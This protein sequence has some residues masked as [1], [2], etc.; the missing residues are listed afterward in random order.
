MRLLPFAALLLAGCAASPSAT[1]PTDQVS[2]PSTETPKTGPAA[3]EP[4]GFAAPA[5]LPDGDRWFV[6]VRVGTGTEPVAERSRRVRGE[7]WVREEVTW[8][9][10]F[11]DLAAAEHGTAQ[12]F[13]LLLDGRG[14][15]VSL[16]DEA[17]QPAGD[18]RIEIAA[19][20]RAG[21]AWTVP[22]PGRNID[23][24]IAGME[25]VETPSGPVEALRV[26]VRE[27]GSRPHR[28]STWYDAGLRPVRSEGRRGDA[29]VLETRAALASATPS[30]EECRA[31]FEWAR[32]NLPAPTAK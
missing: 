13:A 29:E 9:R 15:C 7:G 4:P 11:A 22:M 30:A 16:L 19:P 24:R 12:V 14:L 23:A 32:T 2:A 25:K 5:A 20:F 26:D 8:G 1:P 17:G 10:S 28:W 3:A 27:R 18:T 6:V 21:T 31:A